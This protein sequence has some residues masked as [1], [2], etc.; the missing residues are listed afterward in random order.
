MYYFQ[1]NDLNENT[2]KGWVQN[3]EGNY[4]G[5]LTSSIA[6]KISSSLAEQ[7]TPTIQSGK[8]W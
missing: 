7:V 2:V 3:A 6:T 1:Y 4:W 8:P 5:A